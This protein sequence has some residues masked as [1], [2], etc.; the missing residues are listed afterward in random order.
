MKHLVISTILVLVVLLTLSVSGQEASRNVNED[1][2]CSGPIYDSKEVSRVAKLTYKPEPAYTKEARAKGLKGVIRLTAVLC[3]TGR[4][5]DIVV[6]KGLPHG[7]TEQAV[8]ATR[9]IKFIPAEKDGQ[10][11]SQRARFEYY[12]NVF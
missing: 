10:E 11:V 8:E 1:E 4:V 12:F 3:R 6:T 5:T 7:M 2:A 9:G